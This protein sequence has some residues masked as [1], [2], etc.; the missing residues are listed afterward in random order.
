M[1]SRIAIERNE[2]GVRIFTRELYEQRGLSKQHITYTIPGRLV[3]KIARNVADKLFL[4]EC[5]IVDNERDIEGLKGV[6]HVIP[7][8]GKGLLKKRSYGIIAK[9]HVS[10]LDSRVVQLSEDELMQI[11]QNLPEDMPF[12]SEDYTVLL[13]PEC[14]LFATDDA[15]GMAA[16]LKRIQ[17]PDDRAFELA[18]GR[19][20]HLTMKIFDLVELQIETRNENLLAVAL[21]DTERYLAPELPPEAEENVFKAALEAVERHEQ[22]GL[23]EKQTS[24]VNKLSW[25]DLVSQS[26]VWQQDELFSEPK[27][28]EHMD[29]HKTQHVSNR[30]LKQNHLKEDAEKTQAATRKLKKKQDNT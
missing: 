25:E 22:T 13:P 4:Y 9:P 1:H 15:A 30:L 16:L 11:R 18:V 27:D 7:L 10:L 8:K 20:S 17:L 14:M 29:K 6:E 2:K 28:N 3:R 26:N 21:E 23:L 24:Q 19:M 5:Y 12:V